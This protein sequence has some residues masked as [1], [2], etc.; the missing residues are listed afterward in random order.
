MIRPRR[1][2]HATF[3]TPD[4]DKAIDYY[5]GVLGLVLA[6]REKERAFLASRIGLLSI[7]LE[8]GERERCARMS[9]EVAP[10]AEF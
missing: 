7:V 6:A 1:I 5:T 4:L 8:R 2:G 3:E 10:Q 9:F